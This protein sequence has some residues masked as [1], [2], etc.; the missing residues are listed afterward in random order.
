M[1]ADFKQ[2]LIDAKAGIYDKFY[3]YNREDDGLDYDRGWK[4]AVITGIASDELT[5]VEFQN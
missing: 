3:R 4:A 2:G 1:I 5:I